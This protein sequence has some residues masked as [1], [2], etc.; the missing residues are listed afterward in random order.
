MG[1][2]GLE[3]YKL[4]RKRLFLM[5]ILFLA[6]EIGWAFS[7]TSISFPEIQAAPDGKRSSP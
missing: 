6:V 7:A 5:V 1:L 2:V 4:R 3:L